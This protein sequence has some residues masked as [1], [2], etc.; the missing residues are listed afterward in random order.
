MFI[1][2]ICMKH[3][4]CYTTILISTMLLCC[5]IKEGINIMNNII[6]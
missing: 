6:N 3:N 4:K 5:L 2:Y 1:M